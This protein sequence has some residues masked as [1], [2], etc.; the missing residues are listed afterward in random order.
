MAPGIY[1]GP[2][3]RRL[4]KRMGDSKDKLGA[5]FERRKENGPW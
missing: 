1:T 3:A 2:K 4:V 5:A